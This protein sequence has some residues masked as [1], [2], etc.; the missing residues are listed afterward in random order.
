[1]NIYMKV[2]N[3]CYTKIILILLNNKKDCVRNS[4]NRTIATGQQGKVV[5]YSQWVEWAYQWMQNYKEDKL[6]K[7]WQRDSE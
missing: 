1:M 5:T 3:N 4:S 2:L 7:Y 6:P